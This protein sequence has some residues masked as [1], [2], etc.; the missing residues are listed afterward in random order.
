MG[1]E[2]NEI[3]LMQIKS[4][5]TQNKKDNL[6]KNIFLSEI[7]KLKETIFMVPSTF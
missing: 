3:V 1:K 5:Q 6:L 7:S 4:T 2:S